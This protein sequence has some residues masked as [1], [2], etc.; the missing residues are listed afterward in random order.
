MKGISPEEQHKIDDS[1]LQFIVLLIL[2]IERIEYLET[3]RY[4]FGSIKSFLKNSKVKYE[5]FLK[6]VFKNQEEIKG[7][8][9]LA[10]CNKLTVMQERVELALLNQYILTVDERRERTQEILSKYMIKPM[11]EKAM[12]ELEEKNSF[13]F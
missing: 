4:C 2:I 9:A 3:Q 5:K 6:D 11:L 13:N 1:N 12:A 10:A 8:S 7:D